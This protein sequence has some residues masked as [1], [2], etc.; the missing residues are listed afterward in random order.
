MKGI[1][2][3]KKMLAA[4]G[5]FVVLFAAQF[6][7]AQNITL[8]APAYGGTGC[9]AALV[10]Q[11]SI[12]KGIISVRYN[13]FSLSDV[14]ASRIERANCSIRIPVNVNGRYRLAV[15]SVELR[16]T[17]KVPS[18]VRLSYH[19]DAGFVARSGPIHH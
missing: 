19:A 11:V 7:H 12:S 3:S 8:G 6:A 4:Y 5:I 9:P 16:G 1:V 18:Q 10:P 17:A 13:N 2:L 15:E 14:A